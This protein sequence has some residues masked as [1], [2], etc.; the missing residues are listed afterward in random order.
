MLLTDEDNLSL[1]D[2]RELEMQLHTDLMGVIRKYINRLGI[3]S[4]MGIFDI[5]KTEAMELERATREDIKEEEEKAR[6]REEERM[7]EQNEE[8]QTQEQEPQSDNYFS[9]DQ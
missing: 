3:V 9:V 8:E 4:I 6:K 2:Y 5:V 7:K 1:K